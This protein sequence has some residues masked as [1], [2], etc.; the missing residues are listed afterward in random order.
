MHFIAEPIQL[1]KKIPT[2]IYYII[3]PCDVITTLVLIVFV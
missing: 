2:S 3:I 1:D